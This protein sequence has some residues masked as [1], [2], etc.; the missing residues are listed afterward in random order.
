M[1]AITVRRVREAVER[2]SIRVDAL[3]KGG[4]P[5]IGGGDVHSASENS[6]EAL[7]KVERTT[8]F[9]G[10]RKHDE[11]VD[12]TGHGGGTAGHRAEQE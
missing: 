4:I 2:Y 7:A 9:G 10:T 5:T 8:Q 6:L 1:S 12:V 11:N 3:H